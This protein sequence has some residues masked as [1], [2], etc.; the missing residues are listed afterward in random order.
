MIR[1][2]NIH[3][4]F[5][6]DTDREVYALRGINLE[7][8]RGSFTILIGS[9]GSGKSTLLN[10]VAGNLLP[11]AGRIFINN[12]DVTDALDHK[13][14]SKV[15]RV[16]QDPLAGSVSELTVMENFR[17]AAL[18]TRHKNL[19]IGLNNEFRNKVIA[20]IT[21]LGL[22]LEHKVDQPIGTLSGGQRQALTLLM[23]VMDQTDVLLMDEPSSALDPATA[24]TVMDLAAQITRAHGLT[25]L[26]VTHNLKDAE[27]YGD[28]II[29]LENGSV[30]KDIQGDGKKA[31]SSAEIFSWF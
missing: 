27:T 10:L 15:S 26:L 6:K 23:T 25:T 2:S 16:F 7:I 1:L 19:I 22:G 17:L 9:N 14:S 5:F 4:K 21:Q 24:K 31:L 18:R 20:N 28:R 3:K 8:E 11:D 13:R 29:M 12:S 30:K